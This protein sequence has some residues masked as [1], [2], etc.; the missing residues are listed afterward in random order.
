VHSLVSALAHTRT[1]TATR[2][3]RLTLSLAPPHARRLETPACHAGLLLSFSFFRTGTRVDAWVLNQLTSPV[4][5][6]AVPS[7]PGSLRWPSTSLSHHHVPF[8]SRTHSPTPTSAFPRHRT[9]ARPPLYILPLP[10]VLSFND[11]AEPA[12]RTGHT[13]PS[14][15]THHRRPAAS[16][17]SE[18]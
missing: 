6:P 12:H 15:P 13:E 5:P 7:N 2:A 18:L 17:G 11:S 10:A 1:A 8:P 16:R 9:T 3:M 14:H 4:T